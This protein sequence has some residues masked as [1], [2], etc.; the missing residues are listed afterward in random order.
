LGSLLLGSV[1]VTEERDSELL[2]VLGL[3]G[4]KERI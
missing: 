4:E 2:A 1:V 3:G